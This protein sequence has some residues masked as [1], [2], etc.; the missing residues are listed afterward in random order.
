MC[1]YHPLN[2]IRI[3]KRKVTIRL[4]AGQVIIATNIAGRGTDLKIQEDV[5]KRGGLHVIVSYLPIY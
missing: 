3:L 4:K 1:V 2:L 5:K